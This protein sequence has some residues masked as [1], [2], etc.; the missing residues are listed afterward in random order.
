M[1]T[2][3]TQKIMLVVTAILIAIIHFTSFTDVPSV[4]LWWKTAGF[5]PP[6]VLL[7]LAGKN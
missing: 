3:N 2:D 1:E 5:L 6:C 4:P 7:M